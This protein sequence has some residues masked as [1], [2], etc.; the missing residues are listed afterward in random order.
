MDL[1]MIIRWISLVPSKICVIVERPPIL[2]GRWHAA[3]SG[4][5]TGS[6]PGLS[7]LRQA[8]VWPAADEPTY[9]SDQGSASRSLSESMAR[10]EPGGHGRADGR[11]DRR[12]VHPDYAVVLRGFFAA[13]DQAE[14]V[15]G[16]TVQDAGTGR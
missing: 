8:L 10:P 5:S 16:I 1:P 11:R 14:Q 7:G 6:A 9:G 2:A 13:E 15:T 4:V 12:S 3:G